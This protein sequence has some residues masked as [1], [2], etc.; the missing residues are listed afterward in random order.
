MARVIGAERD[1][2]G[3]QSSMTAMQWADLQ[4]INKVLSVS[5]QIVEANKGSALLS[6]IGR[7]QQVLGA[8]REKLRSL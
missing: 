6:E 4:T 2:L 1:L 5:G 7:A 8:Q 3:G